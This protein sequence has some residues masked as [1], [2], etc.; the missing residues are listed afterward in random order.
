[1]TGITFGT[2]EDEELEKIEPYRCKTGIT[3]HCRC[4][5]ALTAL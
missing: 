5:D 4:C 1:M 2:S 3:S